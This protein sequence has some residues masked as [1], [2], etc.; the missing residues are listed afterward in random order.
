MGYGDGKILSCPLKLNPF[1]TC[2]IWIAFIILFG[3]ACS[4]AQSEHETEVL[5]VTA[6]SG[7]V[8]NPEATVKSLV[9]TGANPT[10][11]S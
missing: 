1:S 11:T 7:K 3:A 4:D 6:E 2:L 10:A 9:I 5:D 8:I